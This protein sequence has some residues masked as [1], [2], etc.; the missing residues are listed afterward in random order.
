MLLS[1]SEMAVAI[2]CLT[3]AVVAGVGLA[4]R[5]GNGLSDQRIHETMTSSA[6][7]GSVAAAAQPERPAA[8]QDG[9]T[10]AG[11]FVVENAGQIAAGRYSLRSPIRHSTSLNEP[12]S[13]NRAQVERSRKLDRRSQVG[14]TTLIVNYEAIKLAGEMSTNHAL[15]AGDRIIVDFSAIEKERLFPSNQQDS[16]RS[17]D[18]T[19]FYALGDLARAFAQ[20]PDGT[21]G[22]PAD[23]L[24]AI[25]ILILRTV[26][27]E[28][29]NHGDQD[30]TAGRDAIRVF[31]RNESLI[32]RHDIL[33]HEKVLVLLRGFRQARGLPD[34]KHVEKLISKIGDDEEQ[35]ETELR[36]SVG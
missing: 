1:K 10:S 13:L 20:K 7:L 2:L 36:R 17:R 15:V 6:G 35:A 26:D 29:W 8:W 3:T 31:P 23:G 14:E 32:I 18:V 27:P 16:P 30:R 5:Q 34:P 24:E 11:R 12:A 22:D 9:E 4:A 28:T 19:R 33:I 21:V 25:R